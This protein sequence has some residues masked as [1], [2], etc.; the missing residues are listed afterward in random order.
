MATLRISLK[1][2]TSQVKFADRKS[3]L[4]KNDNVW[5]N[6]TFCSVLQGNPAVASS[7]E[8]LYD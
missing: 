2:I 3:A 6:A 7:N 4:L 5:K 1:K 8:K